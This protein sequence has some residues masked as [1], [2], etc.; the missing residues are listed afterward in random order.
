MAA[1]RTFQ[2]RTVL[3]AAGALALA[4]LLPGCGFRL[5]GSDGSYNIPFASIYIGLPD[6]SELGTELKRNLR[7]GGRVAIADKAEEADAV[8]LVVSESRSRQILSLNALGRVR[9]YQLN[10]AL[11]YTV[12]D[13]KGAVL[14]PPTPIALRRNLPFDETQVLAKEAEAALLYRDMQADVVQQILR[15]LAALKPAA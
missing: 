2:R 9:E 13:R 10:Y 7:A 1:T 4:A 3:R 12:R 8:L 11:T 14:L 6:T 5:R 15:Q